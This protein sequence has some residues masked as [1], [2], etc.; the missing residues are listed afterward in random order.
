[1]QRTRKTWQR[2]ATSVSGGSALTTDC[3]LFDSLDSHSDSLDS[4]SRQK[5]DDCPS[6]RLHTA[7]LRSPIYSVPAC[8]TVLS[9]LAFKA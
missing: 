9:S 7:A 3:T 1:V 2:Q 8:T 6:V 5:F 4:H